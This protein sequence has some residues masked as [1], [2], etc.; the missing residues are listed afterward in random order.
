MSTISG[1]TSMT[2]S[3]SLGT[4][5]I[6]IQFDLNRNIDGAALDVQ[7]ALTVA[8]RRLPI[9]MTTPPSFRKVN[10]GDFPVLFISQHLADAAA[11]DRARIRRD[12]AGA[13]DFATAGRR[14]GRGLRLAE[15]RD[16]RPG[17]SGG[18]RG[19]Q[20][21]AR[22][23]PY[24]RQRK[25]NSNVPVGTLTGPARTSPCRPPDS[26]RRR[27]TTATSSS[28]GATAPRSSSTR[29]PR[30]RQRRE[31]QDRELVQRPTARSCSASSASP[32]PTRS[33]WSMP[34]APS[35]RR[36]ARRCRPRSSSKSS[37]DR[38]IS[39][40]QSVVD[41]QETLL[42]AIALVVLVIFLFLRSVV[43]DRSFRRWRCRSR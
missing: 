38:S 16:P 42:I 11:V 7:T 20:H 23:H 39:V 36:C 29:S 10:P 31:Q 22:R 43:G 40:R 33:R 6:T 1:I 9:E 37:N 13:A 14:P 34:S 32:T 5:R 12:R 25:T 30:H 17:R 4:T 21:L 41:V 2:S 18:R 35:C 15:I 3:S 28:P 26:S 19:A 8:Q 27:P 24:R